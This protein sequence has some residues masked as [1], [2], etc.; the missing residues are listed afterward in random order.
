MNSSKT[1][2][3]RLVALLDS[4]RRYRN[5]PLCRLDELWDA[6]FVVVAHD[7]RQPPVLFYGNR[8]ALELWQATWDELTS[9]PSAQTAEPGEREARARLLEQVAQRGW[10]DNYRGVRISRAGRRFEISDA[11][12]WNIYDEEQRFLGQAATFESA[13]Y[14]DRGASSS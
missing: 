11:F 3:P 4:Y 13:V 9:M 2:D 14:L 6:P 7:T 8:C 1:D 12:V 5:A 10:I